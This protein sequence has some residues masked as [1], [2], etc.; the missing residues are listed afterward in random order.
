MRRDRGLPQHSR[1]RSCVRCCRTFSLLLHELPHGG[2]MTGRASL[3]P[4]FV[5]LRGS[6]QVGE[7][8]LVSKSLAKLRDYRLKKLPHTEKLATGLKEQIFV[9]K[10]VVEQ[11]ASLFPIA[12]YHSHE[13]PVFRSGGCDAHGV[14]ECFR[15]V[16][17]L[18]P[19]ACLAEP[20]FAAQIVDLQV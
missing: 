11:R 1:L 8:L 13:S 16:V 17:L 19:I 20:G 9:K 14:L 2:N 15:A 5:A 3:R 4:C 7:E 18:K 10:P 12:H 6:F